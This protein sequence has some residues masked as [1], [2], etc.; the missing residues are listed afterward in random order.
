MQLQLSTVAL[1]LRADGLA[2]PLGPRDAA[3]LAWLALEGPTPRAQLVALLWPESLPEAARNTLR[4]RLFQ[5]RK[6]LGADLVCGQHTL[7]LAPGVVHDLAQA[8]TL[9]A[10]VTLDLGG[11]YAAWLLH[12]R[13][14]RRAAHLQALQT[15][16]DQREQAG[17]FEAAL[18]P[19]QAL[20]R[21][22]P[23]SE[24]AHRRVMRLHYLGGDRAAALLAFDACEQVLKNEVGAR[25]SAETLSLLQAIE[26]AQSAG[27]GFGQPKA[28]PVSLRRPPQVLGRDQALAQLQQAWQSHLH[29]ALLG[30]PGQGKTRLL[31]HLAVHWPGAQLVRAR[32]G[33]EAVP[34]ALMARLV[35]Q[36]NGALPALRDTPASQALQQGLQLQLGAGQ[37][38]QRQLPRSLAPPLHTWLA[39]AGAS[40]LALLLDDWQFADEASVALLTPWLAD[41]ST[42]PLR[43]GLA[44]RLHAGPHGER[45]LQALQRL[46]DVQTVTLPPLDEA[47]ITCLLSPLLDDLVAQGQSADAADSATLAQAL[48][49]RVGGNPLHLLESL[50]HMAHNQLPLQPQH[51]AVPRQVRELVAERL[52]QLPADARHLLQ[53]AAVAGQDFGVE[54]AES[55]TGRHALALAEAWGQLEQRGMFGP[56]G[57]SHD[58]FAEVA[59]AQLPTAIAKV[60]HE[61]VATWLEPRLHEPGRLAAHWRAAGR[62]AAAVPHLLNAAMLAWHAARAEETFDFHAQAA[63]ITLAQGLPDQAFAHWFDNAEAMSEIGTAAQTAEC[64]RQLE[65]LARTDAQALRLQFVRAV[66]RAAQGDVDAGLSE[67]GSMLADAIALGDTRLEAEC[68]FA[69]ANRA[70]ADGDFDEALQHLAVGERLQREAGNERLATA[71]AATKAM[72]LGLRGQPRLAQREVERTLPLLAQHNDQATWTVLCSA[73]ALQWL[74]QGQVEPA[75]ADARRAREAATHTSIAPMDL[76]VILRN[77]VD[78]LRWAGHFDEAL[79]VGQEFELRLAPQGQFPSA[80]RTLA[81]LYLSLGRAD[82]ALQQMPSTEQAAALKLRQRERLQLGLLR[83]QAALTTGQPGPLDW[84]AEA[85]ATGDLALAAEWALWGTLHELPPWPPGHVVALLQRLTQAGLQLLAEPLQALATSAPLCPPPH[86]TPPPLATSPWTALLWARRQLQQGQ[87]QAARNTTARGLADLQWLAEHQVPPAFSESF[88]QRHPAHRALQ[89]LGARLRAGGLLSAGP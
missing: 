3:L 71:L 25:P 29:F 24:A 67:V 61:R 48:L 38:P 36:V 49:R 80:Q 56:Q 1:A 12:Q 4:Q 85:L 82:L 53:V 30:E 2:V 51:L 13:E 70:T 39:D 79:A 33:D 26:A 23:L 41:A 76:L 21:L 19:A 86:A 40:G 34:L 37:T 58:V 9:L 20:L 74:R 27:L 83:V 57:A 7:Q 10:D 89:A 63:Q 43:L 50:R 72:V 77:L 22:A 31:E 81:G 87:E 60:L 8:H 35:E 54:L 42:S 14:Q 69:S 88:L 78:T 47:A 75:L 28:M 11:D 84:P 32:P 44:A 17:Q 59:Q 73:Q 45:R 46:G 65:P 6:Q 18:P 62:D 68:R 55:V 52:A 5:L 15:E 16:A 66:L 64:L